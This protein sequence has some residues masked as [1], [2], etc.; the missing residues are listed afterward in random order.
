MMGEFYTVAEAARVLGVTQ[1]RVLEM[2]A[3]EEVEGERDPQ[4]GRWKLPKHSLHRL[5]PKSSPTDQ[6]SENISREILEP[7]DETTQ[8][9]L[10]ELDNLQ[11]EIKR[12]KKRL[13]LA[14]QVENTTWQEE[15]EL[16]LAELEQEREERRQDRVQAENVLQVERQQL[17]E[18]LSRERERVAEL[19]E[20]ANRL[21]EELETERSKGSWRKLFGR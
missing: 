5:V 6:P 16:L 1:R 18:D 20:E 21:Q 11:M 9:I 2:L 8:E 4:S 7:S 3:A 10:G 14:W 12:L 13:E 15:R 17:L 19:Q